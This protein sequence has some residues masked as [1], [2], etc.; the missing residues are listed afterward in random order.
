MSSVP[1]N[2]KGETVAYSTSWLLAMSKYLIKSDVHC[3][4]TF[5][6]SK[7]LNPLNGIRMFIL[8]FIFCTNKV[9]RDFLYSIYIKLVAKRKNFFYNIFY[10]R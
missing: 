7:K 3:F 5:K 9:K 4:K 8:N 6:L 1:S 2:K 10:N